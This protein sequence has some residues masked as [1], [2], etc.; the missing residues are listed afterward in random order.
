MVVDD[1]EYFPPL[2][3]EKAVDTEKVV[4]KG[5][6]IVDINHFSSQMEV[7]ASHPNKCTMGKYKLKKKSATACTRPWYTIVIIVR[8]SSP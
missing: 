5:R 4:L 2:T 8:K 7:I 6:R 1:P 3:I